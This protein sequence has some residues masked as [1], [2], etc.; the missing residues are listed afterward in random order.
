MKNGLAIQYFE[1]YLPDDGKLWQRLRADIPNLLDMGVTAVWIP[2][3]Y[4]GQNSN[5][6]GYG[7]YDLYDIG[8][9]DQKGTVRTKYG[10]FDELRKTVEELQKNNIQVYADTVLN[11]KAGADGTEVF[12]VVEVDPE[13]REIAISEPF[14]IEGWTMFKFPGRAGKYSKFEWF[15]QH[16]TAVDFDQKTGNKAIYKILGE[17]KDFSENVTEEEKGNYDYLMH[18]DVDYN[19]PDVIEEIKRWGL[20]F[21]DKL[22]LDGLRLDALKHIDLEFINEWTHHVREESGRKLYVVGEYWNGD[23]DVLREVLD[24]VCEKLSLFDV[25]LHFRLYEAAQKGQEYDLSKI[26]N[27]T[28]VG[29]DPDNVM[30]FV[31]N[32]DSQIGQSL[33]SWVTDWF[34]PLA[35]ALI[36]LRKDGYPCLFYG[37][38]YGCG[39]ENPIES[40]KDILDPLLKARKDFAYGEQIDYFD[41]PNCIAF[42]RM[43]VPEIQD[44]GL[45]CI[46]SNGEPGYKDITFN[47][48][49]SGRTFY[50]ITGNEQEEIILNETGEGRFFCSGGS[51]SVW[52]LKKGTD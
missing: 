30:T 18:A 17:S 29:D 26:M 48:E 11:H 31:D 44:S 40:K 5:D 20:W 27:E 35:Y 15:H 46:M 1:W 24:K 28:L 49:L 4:K 8:E 37:D 22:N 13:D 9:F 47:Q 39:G 45:V 6:V 50:D 19:N 41:H 12:Q 16:F 23:Y 25:P 34:K 52:I 2:P 3:C 7:A 33:E 14:D 38:Y 42:Q 10:T 51:V 43:G 21:V 32:H 36:L